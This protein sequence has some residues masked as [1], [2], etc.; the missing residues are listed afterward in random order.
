MF[1]K[2]PTVRET[3]F[4]ALLSTSND[5]RAILEKHGAKVINALG[6]MVFALNAGDDAMLLAKVSEVTEDKIYVDPDENTDKMFN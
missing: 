6:A 5:T 4:Q 1:D 2:H 3:Y